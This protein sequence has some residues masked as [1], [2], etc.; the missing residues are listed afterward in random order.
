MYEVVV[1]FFCGVVVFA[2]VACWLFAV[3]YG[4][5]E[6]AYWDRWMDGWIECAIS[7]G[8]GEIPT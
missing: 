4:G 6:G 5:M 1:L 8:R 7:A 3:S 2:V